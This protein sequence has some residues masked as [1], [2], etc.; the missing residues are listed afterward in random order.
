MRYENLITLRKSVAVLRD[1]SHVVS[2]VTILLALLCFL[3]FLRILLTLPLR[4]SSDGADEGWNAFFAAAAVSGGHLYPD[5]N[6]YMVNNYPPLSF[7]LVGAVGNLLG[8]NIVAGRIISAVAFL[9]LAGTVW[10]AARRMNCG[11][12]AAVFAAVLLGAYLIAFSGYVG[13]NDP[14]LLGQAFS[15]GG[16]VLLLR[17]PRSRQAI[18]W[19]ALLLSVAFFVRHDLIV[20]PIVLT[21]WLLWFDRRSAFWLAIFGLIFLIGGLISFRL[22]YGTDLLLHLHSERRYVFTLQSSDLG[23]I[24]SVLTL[25]RWL[26]CCVLP[27]L[28]TGWLFVFARRDEYVVLCVIYVV[29]AFL[30]GAFF[31]QGE[32]VGN[33]VLFDADIALCLAAALFVSR[34]AKKGIYQSSVIILAYLVVPLICWLWAVECGAIR[35]NPQNLADEFR[36]VADI[37]YWT[38]P[39]TEEA[40]VAARDIAFLRERTGPVLCA[41]LELCY[42]ADKGPLFDFFAVGEQFL[43]QRRG[44]EELVAA[45][46][47]QRF[48]AVA[49]ASLEDLHRFM[50]PNV[51]AAILRH[52]RIDHIDDE[53]VFLL[54]SAAAPP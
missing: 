51:S 9:V 49:F 41:T 32:G 50:T 36:E 52:Y 33:N 20:L 30:I 34:S 25:R 15:T 21:L 7:Y 17:E 38:N 22:A 48:A 42:W 44:D 46:K 1:E 27:L 3:P 16:M 2:G 18:F 12:R 45:V 24:W 11:N 23:Y 54:P 40:P 26:Y 10:L 35:C 6:S 31:M 53:G 8:D 29:A 4:V 14:Q 43:L 39:L 13:V 5:Q 28:V 47:R 37:R 19:A